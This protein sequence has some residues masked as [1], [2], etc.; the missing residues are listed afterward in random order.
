MNNDLLNSIFSSMS[1]NDILEK[2]DDSQSH[3]FLRQLFNYL[4][5]DSE[6]YDANGLGIESYVDFVRYDKESKSIV[7]SK[8]EQYID[9]T[10][11]GIIEYP[12]GSSEY[13]ISIDKL[14]NRINAL[15]NHKQTKTR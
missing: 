15:V 2:M 11:D 6:K 9:Y 8:E 1:I 5:T 4:K 12:A 10:D 3:I 13:T 7:V 14:Q